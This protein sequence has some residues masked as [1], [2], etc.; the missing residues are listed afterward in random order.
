MVGLLNTLLVSGLGI[1]L[2]TLL[3]FL[4]GVARLSHNWLLSRLATLYVET[5]RNISYNFV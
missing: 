5:F 3:G 4:L 2:A 1:V